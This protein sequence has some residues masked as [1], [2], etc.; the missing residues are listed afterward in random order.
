MQKIP[1]FPYVIHRDGRIVRLDSRVGYPQGREI[2]PQIKE[3][4]YVRVTLVDR[5]RRKDAL[6]H[7]L[8]AEAFLPNPEGHGFVDHLN[9]DRADNRLENLEWVTRSE[10]ER[11]K[12]QKKNAERD[13]GIRAWKGDY[14]SCA[15]HFG[16]S[17]GTVHRIWR[18]YGRAND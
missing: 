3:D 1:D 14:K 11:R 10:N 18:E 16:C 6:L 15:E 7:R 13:E 8:L 5:G 17:A 9:G 2:K 12:F 4:G